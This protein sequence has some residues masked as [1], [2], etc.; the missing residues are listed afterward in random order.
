M[1]F[2]LLSMLAAAAT[3]VAAQPSAAGRAELRGFVDDITVLTGGQVARFYEPVCVLSEGLPPDYNAVVEARVD[4]LARA[5][6]I[7][8]D[9]R[10]GCAPNLIVLVADDSADVAGVL[11]RRRPEIFEGLNAAEISRVVASG[12]P[13]RS[14]QRTEAS[15]ANGEPILDRRNEYLGRDVHLFHGAPAALLRTSTRQSLRL[16]VVVF[17]V[18]AIDGLTLMQIADHAAMLGL[19]PTRAAGLDGGRSILSLFAASPAGR[20]ELPAVTRWDL[21]YLRALYRIGAAMDGGAHRSLLT[22]LAQQDLEGA[23]R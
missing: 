14:W 15:W 18:D 3:P 20:R 21:A 10:S 13:V 11:R 2:L 5:A 1:R 22:R 17:D 9:K 23:R 6:G 7:A 8:V 12:G 19:A 4:E 16:S